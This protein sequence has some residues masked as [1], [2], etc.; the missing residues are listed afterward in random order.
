[1]K[2]KTTIKT[3]ESNC[4]INHNQKLLLSGSCFAENMGRILKNRKF[5]LLINP[6]GISY[7]P[8]SLHHLLTA[9]SGDFQ[10]I[11]K[12]NGVYYHFQLHSVF[13]RLLKADFEENLKQC[14]NYQ[15]RHLA[16]TTSIFISYGTAIVHE[17]KNTNQVVNNCHKQPAAIFNK[18][19]L[20]VDEITTSF[21]QCREFL[22][23]KYKKSFQFIFTVSPVR[24]LKEGF[25]QNQ[26]SKS[27]LHL[28]VEKITK[29]PNCHYFPSFEIMMDDLRD[30]RFYSEDLL[31]PNQTAIDY[32][33]EKFEAAFCDEDC[34]QLNKK[35]KSIQ[36]AM[37]HRAFLPQSNSH[38]NFL[39][40][41][42]HQIKQLQIES[43][44]D[45]QKEIEAIKEK[46]S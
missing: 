4:N 17:L 10:D 33:W 35:I 44:L 40:Q 45:F 37:Q 24:H 42:E 21:E 26:I 46:L 7:N 3:V 18:R 14:S 22:E 16:E 20:S 9:K 32:I 1:M 2:L 30:Y 6:L 8:I 15:D 41:L 11:Q 38:K 23:K 25:R 34:Q 29:L 27:I 31:H 5:K 13:N 39:K 43:K 12:K 36:Q 19:F 28:A